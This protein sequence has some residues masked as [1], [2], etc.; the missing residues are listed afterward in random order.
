VRRI[1]K[2]KGISTSDVLIAAGVAGLVLYLSSSKKEGPTDTSTLGNTPILNASVPL[3]TTIGNALANATKAVFESPIGTA[4]KL[5]VKGQEA[6]LSKYRSQLGAIGY[7]NA[8]DLMSTG[9]TNQLTPLPLW[10]RE[11]P[12]DINQYTWSPSDNAY[13]LTSAWDPTTVSQLSSGYNTTLTAG[14]SYTVRVGTETYTEIMPKLAE[15]VAATTETLNQTIQSIIYS[16]GVTHTTTL[17]PNTGVTSFGSFVETSTIL[18]NY[19]ETI[20]YTESYIS[21]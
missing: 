21:W 1:K 12:T 11:T 17:T 9:G 2:S 20:P 14:T 15:T 4:L 19:T 10:T 18:N 6:G 13:I 8:V 7:L 3:V 5:V 16:P